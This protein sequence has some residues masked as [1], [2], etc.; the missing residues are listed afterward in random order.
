MSVVDIYPPELMEDLA[1]SGIGPADMRVRALGPNERYATNTPNNVDGF[2]IPYF[3]INGKPL[4]FYRVR[5]YAADIKYKQLANS[6]NHVY[7]PPGFAQ[8]VQ[9]NPKVILITEGEKKAA[10]AVARGIPCVGFGGV[11]SWR[12]RILY[13]PKGSSLAQGQKNSVIA[14]LPS[15]SE[16]TEK[17]DA[18]ATGMQDLINLLMQTDAAVVICYDT[19]ELGRT[20]SDVQA[21]AASLGYELRFRGIPARRIRQLKLKPGPIFGQ[22]KC[23]VDDFLTHSKLGLAEFQKQL[24]EVLDAR[25]AFPRHPNPKAYVN[26]RLQRSRMPRSDMQALSTAILCDLDSR[27]ARLRCPDDDRLYYFHKGTHKLLPVHFNYNR[28]FANSPFG[29]HLYRSYNLGGADQRLLEWVE[30]QFTGEEPITDVN[31]ERVVTSRG[32]ALYYHITQ[33]QMLKITKDSIQILDNGTEDILFESDVVEDLD[34]ELLRKKLTEEQSQ[35]TLQPKWY[36]TLKEARIPETGEDNARRSLALLYSISPWFYR[37]RG[38]Q[39]PIE[40]MIAEPGS[41]KSTLYQLRL[42][43]LTGQ[44]R[45]RN[46]PRDMRDWTASVAAT[47]GLHVTD[48][49]NLSNSQLRQELSDEICRIITE[50]NPT[51]EAR[52]LYT[53]N[54]LVTTPVKTVFAITAVR[55]PFN[56]PDILQRSIITYLDKGDAEVHYEADWEGR[57][58][59]RFGGREGWIAHHAVVAHRLLKAIHTQWDPNYKARFRLINVEQLLKLAAPLFGWDSDWIA[60]H[61]EEVRDKSVASSDWALEG[62][63]TFAAD[64]REAYGNDIQSANFPAKAVSEW[65]S[66]EDDFLKCNVLTSS[67]QLSNYIAQH[68]NLV[69]RI[70][71][72]SECPFLVGNRKV[73]YVHEPKI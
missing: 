21:A 73:F 70:A 8:L 25:Q 63:C 4:P 24:Q 41:G 44:P 61:L 23:G 9:N 57:Q 3:D 32:D 53:D 65:A 17:I 50:P 13:I 71:G 35:E 38:T 69:A 20:H 68:K 5:L 72:I 15:G 64:W 18:L 1:R 30:T 67:R 52:K 55:Q 54:T 27:G 28:G 6:P 31:P 29:V 16:A 47:G 59:A 19:D 66:S 48:N 14:K 51:I 22:E 60:G 42:D 36:L 56:N 39:L 58:L 46:A 2:V 12:N 43:I 26:K 7:F 40:M 37:W 49:V 11:D 45:L 34:V 62:L 33:G 10:S